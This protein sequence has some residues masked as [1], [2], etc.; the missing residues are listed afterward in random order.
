VKTGY[1]ECA[2]C[3][4]R[5]LIVRGVPPLNWGRDPLG[6]VAVTF[7]HPIVGRF[8][9]HDE[10]PGPLE[11]AY[12]VHEC[13]QQAAAPEPALAERQAAQR[14]AWKS[15]IAGLHRGQRNQRGRRP[16]PQI[17]GA[18]IPPPLPGMPPPPTQE[19][20]HAR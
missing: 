4:V 17:T 10:Q 15:A 3:H 11:H 18:V 5:L 7:A 2:H 8:L 19:G 12:S 20:T 1:R 9:A 13:G 14:Q 6:Q 16:A